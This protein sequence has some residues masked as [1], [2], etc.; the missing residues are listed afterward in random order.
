MITVCSY[1]KRCVRYENWIDPVGIVSELCCSEYRLFIPRKICI[2]VLISKIPLS[3]TDMD[4]LRTKNSHLGV[5]FID[6]QLTNVLLS[7]ILMLQKL[8]SYHCEE[9][10][11]IYHLSHLEVLSQFSIMILISC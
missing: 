1:F 9:N 10:L 11:L 8:Y 2:L 7:V 3:N 4:D 6:I 5:Y